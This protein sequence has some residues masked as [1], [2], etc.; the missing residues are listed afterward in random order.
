MKNRESSDW[1]GEVGKMVVVV[2]GTGVALLFPTFLFFG[3]SENFWRAFFLFWA[4]FV[5]L[6]FAISSSEKKAR[7]EQELFRE[8]QHEQQQAERHRRQEEAREEVKRLLQNEAR[9]KLDEARAS[10]EAI[11]QFNRERLIGEQFVVGDEQAGIRSPYEVD[12]TPAEA[13]LLSAIS[14][15]FDPSCL[16][17]DTYLDRGDGRT[18]QVDIIAICRQGVI[19]IESKGLGGTIRGQADDAE[20]TLEPSGR[21]IYNPIRQNALH[22]ESIYRVLD[23]TEAQLR[24][25]AEGEDFG[26]LESALYRHAQGQLKG[27]SLLFADRK[28]SDKPLLLVFDHGVRPDFFRIQISGH[29]RF[30]NFSSEHAVSYGLIAFSDDDSTPDFKFLP[31]WIHSLVVFNEGTT[32]PDIR[33]YS[34]TCQVAAAH[35]VSEAIDRILSGDEVLSDTEVMKMTCKIRRHRVV[36]DKDVREAHIR[37]IELATGKYGVLE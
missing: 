24:K 31:E 25:A 11:A 10:K 30:R 5:A 34:S 15:K 29:D 1:A 22:V 8:Q 20:W 28:D 2:L 27:R 17:V 21:R 7:E 33:L 18:T 35:R 9:A 36:P 32:F 37:N 6:G 16:L 23:P 14:S 19:V 3:G 13:A 26:S 4:A 12:M